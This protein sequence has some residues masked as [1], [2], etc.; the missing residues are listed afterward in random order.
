MIRAKTLLFLLFM[1]LLS[2]GLAGERASASHA[3][4]RPTGGTL[5]L[6]TVDLARHGPIDLGGEWGFYWKR[7][8]A[9]E[10]FQ[11]PQPPARLVQVP[12]TWPHPG[13]PA[14]PHGYGT[15]RLK[16]KTQGQ[17]GVLALDKVDLPS[18]CRIWVD[19]RL[20]Y[21]AGRLETK[22]A[23]EGSHY[24]ARPVYFAVTGPEFTITLQTS[25][26]Y[27]G[28]GGLHGRLRL[29]TE[30]QIHGEQIGR[31]ALDLFL[32]G[33]IL[34]MGLYH[35]GLFALRRSDKSPLYFGILCLIVAVRCLFTNDYY[36]L[37]LVPGL[38]WGIVNRVEYLTFYLAVPTFLMYLREIFPQE[39]SRLLIRASQVVTAT[40]ALIVVACPF[41]IYQRTMLPFELF[42]L[43]VGIAIITAIALAVVR[44]RE[45]SLAALTGFVLLFLTVV[46]DI[47]IVNRVIPGAYIVPYGLVAFI[48]SQSFLLSLRYSRAFA[49]IEALSQRL[50][51]LDKLK[52][53]FLANTSHEL[54]T[55]LNG[56][57]GIAE[58]LMDGATGRLPDPTVQNL[59]M[60]VSSGKRLNSLVNN[61]L[62]FSKLKNRDIELQ[63]KPVDLKQLVDLVL[64]LSRPLAAGKPIVLVADVP[65]DLPA[66]E[67]DEDRISQVL[68]NLVGNAVKFTES[69]EV[70]VSAM[71]A[72]DRLQVT[73]HDTGI[74]I[75]HGKFD[76]IFQSFE[77]VDASIERQYGGTGLGLS[78]TKQLVELHGGRIWVESE[79]GR[80]SCFHFTLPVSSDL[81]IVPVDRQ[82]PVS[83]VNDD[84]G[85]L[86]LTSVVPAASDDPIRI[87]VVDDELVNLQVLV[88]HLSLNRYSVTKAMNGLEALEI[89]E[90]GQRFDIVLLDV[91]MPKMSGY[92]VCQ[93]I[94]ARHPA[95]ELP[96]LLL[97][98]KDR[99]SDLVA[100]FDAGA[101]DYLTKPIAKHELLSRIKTHLNLSRFHHAASRF[102]PFELIQLLNK[103]SIIEVSLG[104][105][106][107]KHMSVLFSDIRSFTT[108][109][110]SMTPQEN[111]NFINSYLQH[112]GPLIREHHGF[113]DKFIGDSIMAL[114]STSADDA[115][116]AGITMQREL[117]SYN[118]GRQRA[119]YRPI[120]VG[121]GI[122]TGD[123]MLGTVGEENRMEGT[124]ISDAVNL[125]ARLEGLTKSYGVP[126]LI[127]EYTLSSLKAP[128][129]FAIRFVERVSVKGKSQPV[130][131][132]E[133]FDG[134]PPEVYEGKMATRQ[135]FGEGLELFTT[136]EHAEARRRFEACLAQ[137]PE[138]KVAGVYLERCD[139]RMGTRR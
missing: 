62:D 82:Q 60:I 23:A 111:F 117:V 58:S 126:M 90:S 73:V 118:Q 121:I 85:E 132:Y 5:D 128:D 57:I 74:G 67:G 33:S 107:Q 122:N 130:S 115:V 64:T 38:P 2:L 12:G 137:N 1:A 48:F 16:V 22:P 87:L 6:R 134:D 92:E 19:D 53:E 133:V 21:S 46:H 29:G 99:V 129:D 88:N 14:E 81:A 93:T 10:D 34:L 55:P 43:V 3:A 72:G 18:S 31:V 136:G 51:S 100:G 59:G 114:F 50:M 11:R 75:P 125:A 109:S 89:L 49:T 36:I 124:V 80:G 102:V 127:S 113:I 77:Q 4:V 112:M 105:Q 86:V 95:S 120:D 37:N 41:Q 30:S 119:G 83:R 20:V 56:I 32:F 101:N 40:C 103:E 61:L 27:E 28:P 104:D 24:F 47:L 69:G 39:T 25:H 70:R 108:L 35:L 96:I 63:R 52:N 71:R 45:G 13:M 139:E 138:D 68:H 79:V 8:L 44:R 7:F 76:A 116:R 17:T 84:T 78:I 66:A 135:V 26:F 42:T 131:V 106:V 98:A 110:E 91:M 123:L 94:R 9:P 97:T 54:R 65:E 15:Y